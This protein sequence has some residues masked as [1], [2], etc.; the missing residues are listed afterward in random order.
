MLSVGLGRAIDI[1]S[2]RVFDVESTSPRLADEERALGRM[3][4]R[5]A[6]PRRK[7]I[8][9]SFDARAPTGW[10]RPRLWRRPVVAS[11]TPTEPMSAATSGSSTRT[12]DDACS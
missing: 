7:R 12:D 5:A 9:S 11:P 8:Q 6:R 2:W 1:G 3:L 4:L 10:H